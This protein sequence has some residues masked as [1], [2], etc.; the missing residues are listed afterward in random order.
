MNRY[1]FYLS[2]E[3][4]WDAFGLDIMRKED[5]VQQR[6]VAETIVF[7]DVEPH[8]I[9]MDHVPPLRLSYEDAQQ[10]MDELFRIGIRPSDQGS[11]GQLAAVKYHL[12]DMRKLVFK[13]PRS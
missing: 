3:F 2:S 13:E 10:L 8:A 7:Q 5:D 4:M 9:S 6:A 11:P 12:E 1:K